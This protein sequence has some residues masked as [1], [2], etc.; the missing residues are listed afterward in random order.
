MITTYQFARKNFFKASSKFV[1]LKTDKIAYAVNGIIININ[2]NT[3]IINTIN[4]IHC[5]LKTAYAILSVFSLTNLLLALK[6]FF[7]ANW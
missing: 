4:T 5:V 6:K 1:K 3:I 2:I 7:L